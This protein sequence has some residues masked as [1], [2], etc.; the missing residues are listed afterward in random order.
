[1]ENTK[2]AI[3]FGAGNNGKKVLSGLMIEYGLNITAFADNAP[4]KWGGW[5]CGLP[6]INPA[7]IV[8][9]NPDFIIIAVQ[10]FSVLDKISNQLNRY[11]ID[12]EKII[13][14]PFSFDYMN[15]YLDQRYRWI[16]SYADYI[17]D[18]GVEGCVAECGVFRGESAKFIN[19]FFKD[20]K[21]Y[22]FDTFEGF[23]EDDISIEQSLKN[24][25][26]NGGQFNTFGMFSNTSISKVLKKMAFPENII[27]KKGYFPETAERLVNERF[28]F[29]NLDMDLYVPMKSG[30]EW[31][32]PR[33]NRKG[34]ILCHDYYHSDLP[35]V[36]KA[37]EDTE[38]ALGI[39]FIKVPIG[40]QCSIALIKYY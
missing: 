12:K 38:K 15:A 20:R 6:V 9:Y 10:D 37:V 4:A 33:L 34:C 31:F 11:G 36:K 5:Y 17:R 25:R 18:N 7:E 23:N 3:I 26:F 2:K 29:V 28:C 35:G 21:F 22:L 1:M 8:S 39:D 24:D 32:W 19:R 16:D 40:D 14:L 27:V 13:Q 30:I